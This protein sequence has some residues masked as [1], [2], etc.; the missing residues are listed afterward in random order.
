MIVSIIRRAKMILKTVTPTT[1]LMLGEV[2][3]SFT[4]P[5]IVGDIFRGNEV[6]VEM[7]MTGLECVNVGV[8]VG[9]AEVGKSVDI[10][11]LGISDEVLVEGKLV[12]SGVKVVDGSRLMRTLVSTNGGMVI[13]SE[14]VS[15]VPILTRE[16]VGD[17]ITFTLEEGADGTEETVSSVRII[18]EELWNWMPMERASR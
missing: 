16:E 18:V 9:M 5:L 13:D 4:S 10:E 11:A 15:I 2:L 8:C 3:P 7:E 17:I 14:S 1:I 12:E 6:S